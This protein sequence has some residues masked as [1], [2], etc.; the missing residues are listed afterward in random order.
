MP[1]VNP[2]APV[3][4]PQPTQV[5]SKRPPSIESG[6]SDDSLDAKATIYTEEYLKPTSCPRCDGKGWKH[7]TS[8]KH[9]KIPSV[10]CK[11]C[12]ACKACHSSG[13]VHG[14][15]ACPDCETKGFVHASKE[16]DHDAP[17]KLRCFFCKNC[18]RCLG[19]GIVDNPAVA[20]AER[21]KERL[22]SP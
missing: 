9:D 4:W 17:E 1:L 8:S 21:V 13:Q 2:F 15:I 7:D 20:E 11:N 16:R 19:I 12:A 18:P 6:K 10:K 5:D 22:Q 3:M 14:K